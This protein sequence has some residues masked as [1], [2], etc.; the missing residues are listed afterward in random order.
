M[1][2]GDCSDQGLCCLE[3]VV[4]TVGFRGWEVVLCVDMSDDRASSWVSF[5][6]TESESMGLNFDGFIFVGLEQTGR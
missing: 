6:P 3:G 1:D 5:D 4:A 2:F